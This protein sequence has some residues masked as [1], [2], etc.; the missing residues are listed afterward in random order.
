M[1]KK[2]QGTHNDEKRLVEYA[3]E[4]GETERTRQKQS[5]END[6]TWKQ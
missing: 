4:K 5:Q 6:V 2:R 1:A 3:T